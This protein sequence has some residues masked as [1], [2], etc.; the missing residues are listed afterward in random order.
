MVIPREKKQVRLYIQLTTTDGEERGKKVDRNPVNPHIKYFTFP[1][2]KNKVIV[3]L[4]YGY[5]VGAEDNDKALQNHI[6]IS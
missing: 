3:D 5:C 2:L 6:Q 4:R 1:F